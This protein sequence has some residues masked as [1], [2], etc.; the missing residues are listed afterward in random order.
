MS[1]VP[2]LRKMNNQQTWYDISLPLDATLPVWPGDPPA[3]IQRTMSIATGHPLNTSR[4]DASLHW[5]THVDAPFH[6]NPEGW[7]IDEIPPAILMGKVY[8]VN[9]PEVKKITRSH[10]KSFPLHN[11]QRLLLKTR[12]SDFWNHKPLTFHNDFSALDR[13]SAEYLVDMGIKLVGIDYLSLDLYEAGDLPV[14]KILFQAN[15]I[16]VEGLDLRK[17]LPGWYELICLP[18]KITGGDGAPA[19]VF[20]KNLDDSL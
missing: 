20:L 3:I 16:G 1:A 6:L 19:R 13:G 17:I 4:I 10:L 5:G 12:N 11:V 8:V 14:H 2:S 9:I 15:I 18:L 7:K